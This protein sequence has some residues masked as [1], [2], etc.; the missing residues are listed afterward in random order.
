[1]RSVSRNKVWNHKDPFTGSSIFFGRLKNAGFENDGVFVCSATWKDITEARK[2][3]PR[4]LV[5]RL[6]GV[7]H[8]R[9]SGRN[10]Y[11]YVKQRRPALLP[12]AKAVAWVPDLPAPMSAIFNRYLN[13]H[14]IWLLKNADALIFQS[15]VSRNMYRAYLSHRPDDRQEAVIFNGVDLDEFRPRRTGKLDGAPA[16]IISAAIQ[17][18]VKRLPQA[19][20]LINR[21]AD[22]FPRIR[23]H[24]LGALD[25]LVEEA[26]ST[27][28]T[29]RCTFHGRIH[30]ENLATV[31]S[32]AD[33]QLSLGVLDPCPNVVCEGLASGLPVLTP[34]ESGA[35]ELIGSAN[36]HWAIQEGIELETYH[37]SFVAA[38]TPAIPVDP[39]VH[40]FHLIMDDLGEAR[41]RARARAEAALD[42]RMAAAKYRDFVAGV[43]SNQDVRKPHTTR[44]AP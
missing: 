18:L 25:A 12:A 17:R 23:L 13:K 6:D 5:A 27:L 21:L 15:Q 2:I 24:V 32:A 4:C 40:A 41:Q 22:S 34:A 38:L 10:I 35:A 43:L 33:L 29:S 7:R 14:E 9:L 3:S 36:K 16:V 20:R 1:M 28:D 37:S 19:I 30:H 39:Y 11:G 26:V 44:A 42:I 31:Y 8:D